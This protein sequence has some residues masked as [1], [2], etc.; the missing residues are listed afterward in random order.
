VFVEFVGFVEFIAPV[1][2]RF[3]S[4]LREFNGVKVYCVNSFYWVG[5]VL[6]VFIAALLRF[7]YF[8]EEKYI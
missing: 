5:F 6:L 4:S 1:E 7:I 8:Y 3:A 2:C